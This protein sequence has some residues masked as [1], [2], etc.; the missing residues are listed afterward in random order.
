M[1]PL[2]LGRHCSHSS[3]CCQRAPAGARRRRLACRASAAPAPPAA[4]LPADAA[5]PGPKRVSMVSLGCAKNVV[6]GEVMLGD[7]VRSGFEVT[8]DSEAADAIIINTCAFV[9]DA[10]A[11]S[12]EVQPERRAAPRARRRLPRA[13]ALTAAAAA[14]ACRDRGQAIVEAAGL[15]QDGKRRQILVTGCLAQR[16]GPALAADLPEADLVMGFENYGALPAALA[17][18]LGTSSSPTAAAA[19]SSSSSSGSAGSRV[20]V[21]QATVPFRAEW[22]RVRLTPRHTAYLRV[23]EGCN[24]ACTFCAIPGFRGKFRSKGWEPLLDEARRLVASGVVEL[25]LIAEDTNQYGQDRRDGRGLAELLRALSELE[26]LRW[27]RILYAYPSYFD[28]ALIAE[29]ASNPKVCK[30][31]D[32]PLQH[33]HNLTL[34]AMNRPPQAHTTALLAKLRDNIPGL[35]LR[36][37]FITGFP[38]ETEEAH[39][40]LVEFVR[41]FRFE[42]AGAFVYS[43][44]DGTPAA[45]LPEQVPQRIRQR[46]RDELVQVQQAISEAFAS[47]LV[48]SEVDVLVDGVNED[49]WLYGRTQWDAPDVDPVVFV[50][51]PPPGAAPAAPLEPSSPLLSSG[52]RSRCPSAVRWPVAATGRH[53]DSTRGP[54]A[55]AAA[56]AA[57]AGSEMGDAA[58]VDEASRAAAARALG[59]AQL[60]AALS[61]GQESQEAAWQPQG[62]HDGDDQHADFGRWWQRNAA[63]SCAGL[64][65]L[66][67]G[68]SWVLLKGALI[69]MAVPGVQTFL[70]LASAAVALQLAAAWQLV[71]PP[72]ISAAA[73][74]GALVQSVLSSC[75]LLTLVTLLSRGSVYMV[76]CAVNVLPLLLRLSR[77]ADVSGAKTWLP[78]AVQ[79][80][81]RAPLGC[82]VAGLGLELLADA[83]SGMMTLALL[84]CFSGTV[85]LQLL[86]KQVKGDATLGHRIH[87]TDFLFRAR[88]LSDLEDSA[89][90]ATLGFMSA[91]LPAV[92]ALLLGLV[93][94]LEG[95]DLVEHEPSVPTLSVLM[96][97]CGAF[98][99]AACLRVM[100]AATAYGTPDAQALLTA[101]A[102]AL[103][104]LLDFME[105][106]HVLNVACLLGVSLAVGGSAAATLRGAPWG[107]WK[108]AKSELLH[109]V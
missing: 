24:H 87:D 20:Q 90:P 55:A 33:I 46:R 59:Q 14:A 64:L 36:T 35:A 13:A 67:Q 26:G 30:Y 38:G 1:A 98:A 73:V 15:N 34:L 52:G 92:P 105:R 19:S 94:G 16:Y 28:D 22:D 42:R 76:L 45:E 39:R 71:E 48:G 31:I 107:S 65:V 18:R 68:F 7:L 11:E 41:C 100:L 109:I 97:S 91:A 53:S 108:A 44:E 85:A 61:R 43:E 25:N 95:R 10:K 104:I 60:D 12:L 72:K 96:L 47:S 51:G 50:S 79:H 40:E 2:A 69:S 103:A 21:G 84:L 99:G 5:P 62:Q 66:A 75:Q 81:M 83:H 93:L 89:S 56:A 78:A 77:V 29:I 3:S 9:E 32:M 88:Q 8:S 63:L 49:G 17:E 70:H 86:W 80:H 37:T 4:P 101:A 74:K 23:A 27:L 6:D 102:G 106:A 82:A 57:A 58:E 54:A